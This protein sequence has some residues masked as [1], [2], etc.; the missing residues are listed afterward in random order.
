M[1]MAVAA[2]DAL[3]R[4]A[5]NL[6]ADAT[7]LYELTRLSPRQ[8]TSAIK[9]G[10]VRPDTPRQQVRAGQNFEQ[11]FGAAPSRLT[12]AQKLA[13]LTFQTLSWS[14]AVPM[15]LGSAGVPLR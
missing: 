6:P 7:S 1:L 8:L 3:F 2:N 4:H 10:E 12:S 5:G 14:S 11:A 9:A 15:A 13:S